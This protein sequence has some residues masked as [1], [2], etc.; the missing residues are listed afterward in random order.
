MNT[1]SAKDACRYGLLGRSLAHSFSPRYFNERFAREGLPYSYAPFELASIDELP[2]LLEAMP[3][4][5]GLNVTLPYKRE[6]LRYVDECS[7][8]VVSLGAA[9]VLKITRTASGKPYLKAYNTDVAGFRASL[10]KL[11][12][13]ARPSALVFGT[14]GAASAVGYVLRELGIPYRQ[15]SRS[16]ERAELTYATLSSEVCSEALLWVN[17]TSVGLQAGECLPLPYACLTPAHYVYDLIYNPSP[18]PYLQQASHY[19]ARTMDGLLMLYGQADEA[20]RIWSSDA[21]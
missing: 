6:V 7:P 8:E 3:Q 11:L 21:L 2:A 18:T 14:G 12:G 17:A 10:L 15:V 19:G 1:S 13:V 9:N 5:V 16:P 4:L 20:W